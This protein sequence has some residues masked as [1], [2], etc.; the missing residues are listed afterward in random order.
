MN[1]S[2]QL[3]VPTRSPDRAAWPENFAE[4]KAGADC[5]MCGNDFTAEDIG[6]GLLVSKGRF[7]NASLWRSGQVRGYLVVIFTVRHVAEPTEMSPEEAT[8]FRGRWW[9]RAWPSSSCSAR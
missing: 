5:P 1:P 9:R 7:S 6:W 2:A 4:H 8:G 3:A